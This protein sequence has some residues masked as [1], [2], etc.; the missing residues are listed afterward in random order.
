MES[1]FEK[2]IN[3]SLCVILRL[4]FDVSGLDILLF[5]SGGT[6]E[7]WC[8]KLEIEKTDSDTVNVNC[9]EWAICPTV[10]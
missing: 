3:L 5:T 9:L 2:S 10:R 8:W 4:I 6:Q 7:M 1:R